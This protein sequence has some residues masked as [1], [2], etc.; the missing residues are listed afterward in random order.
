MFII[1]RF[2]G[3][4]KNT[5]IE[6]NKRSVEDSDKDYDKNEDQKSN[7]SSVQDSIEEN[8]NGKTEKI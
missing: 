3:L 4:D 5:A 2:C 8:I 1:L 7:D 6:I